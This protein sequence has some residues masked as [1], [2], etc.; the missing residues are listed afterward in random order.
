MVR[1]QRLEQLGTNGE[2]GVQRGLGIL[3]GYFARSISKW[4]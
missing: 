3:E 1:L 4:M 2:D